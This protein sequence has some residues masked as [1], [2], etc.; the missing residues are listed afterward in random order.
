MLRNIA[1]MRIAIGA[2]SWLMPNV[3]GKLFGLD[4]ANNPQAPYLA[5]L[6]GVRDLALGV[7]ALQSTGQTQ[8]QILQLG[9]AC[10]VADTFAGIAGGRS[11][12]LPRA[13]TVMVTG[14]AI[15]AAAMSAAAIGEVEQTPA[16]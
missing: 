10:D 13:A 1:F 15:A 11:G 16:A 2:A 14:A 7:G 5:R 3:A 4:T 9:M 12:Y 6:F 8:K